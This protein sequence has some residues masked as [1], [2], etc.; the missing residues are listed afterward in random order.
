VCSCGE[1][2]DGAA[3]AAMSG[4]EAL[5]AMWDAVSRA[6][7]EARV[8]LARWRGTEPPTAPAVRAPA[9]DTA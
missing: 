9:E 3:L 1:P 2:L 6:H 5:A 8:E 4:E 7:H